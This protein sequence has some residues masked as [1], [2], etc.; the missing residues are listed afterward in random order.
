M[1][2]KVTNCE[3]NLMPY[4]LLKQ[5]FFSFIYIFYGFFWLDA[6]QDRYIFINKSP[7]TK[8]IEII[9]IKVQS[10]NVMIGGKLIF[11]ANQA[12]QAII[13]TTPIITPIVLMI[14]HDI[15]NK[16][17]NFNSFSNITKLI[18]LVEINKR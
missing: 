1:H 3:L 15:I 17:F 9:I 16:L 6:L 4:L 11:T 8:A 14:A 13:K 7:T 10:Q 2:P 5:S 12:I 18:S